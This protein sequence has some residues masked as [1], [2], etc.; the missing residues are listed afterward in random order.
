MIIKNVIPACSF[1]FILFFNKKEKPLLIYHRFLAI[2]A[3]HI[4]SLYIMKKIIIILTIVLLG[5]AAFQVNA[6]AGND[7]PIAVNQ[8][9]VAAQQF[10]KKH[11]S[12][13]KVAMAKTEA[14]VFSKNYDVVFTTG[15]KIEFDKKG[16]WTEIDCHQSAVPNAL[17]PQAIA[18]YVKSNYPALKILSIEKDR[19]EYDVKLSNKMEI[20]FNKQFQVIDID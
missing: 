18:K 13:K 11:F 5:V 20:T 4:K 9:P 1:H 16:I 19:D 2:F 8:L 12:N 15:E 14:G 7:K 6:L 10:L 17:V 3:T